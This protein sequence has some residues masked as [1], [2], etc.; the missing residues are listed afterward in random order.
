MS[1]RWYDEQ[2]R[3]F[4]SP[5]L[6]GLSETGQRFPVA[7]VVDRYNAPGPA[8]KRGMLR[9]GTGVRTAEVGFIDVKVDRTVRWDGIH[10][11]SRRATGVG[12]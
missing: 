4:V 12:E 7:V 11:T 1:C 6:L 5:E 8:A 9:R 10:V 3:L 2:Q